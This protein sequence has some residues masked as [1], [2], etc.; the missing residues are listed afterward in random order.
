LDRRYGPHHYMLLLRERFIFLECIIF[1]DDII[2]LDD[3]RFDVIM[4]RL[5]DRIGIMP[6]SFSPEARAMR[7]PALP[8]IGPPIELP[9][10]CARAG[11]DN[12]AR[13]AVIKRA[14]FIICSMVSARPAECRARLCNPRAEG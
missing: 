6:E 5:P 3:M 14:F 10:D 9:P 12:R 8:P 7:L 2:F 11:A 1:F 4:P 13:V